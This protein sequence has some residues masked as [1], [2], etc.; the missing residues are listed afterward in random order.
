MNYRHWYRCHFT[1]LFTLK[2]EKWTYAWHKLTSLYINMSKRDG[3][4]TKFYSSL[5]DERDY[6]IC[7]TLNFFVWFCVW[8]AIV[9]GKVATEKNVYLSQNCWSSVPAWTYIRRPITK[10]RVFHI[11]FPRLSFTFS[12]KG[13]G[14]GFKSLY[15]HDVV[16]LSSAGI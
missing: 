10:M 5:Q 8:K 1:S 13:S 2:D 14:F 16:C 12:T 4:L 9:C 6:I 7:L 15:W 11:V 3:G